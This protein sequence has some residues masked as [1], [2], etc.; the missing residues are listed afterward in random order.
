MEYNS[1]G[2]RYTKFTNKLYCNDKSKKIISNIL[3]N[4]YSKY[5]NDNN[6]YIDDDLVY[7]MIPFF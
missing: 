4:S 7:N 2:S 3:Y 5:D 6:N 1:Y